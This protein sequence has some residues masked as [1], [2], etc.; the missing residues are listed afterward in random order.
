MKN[1]AWSIAVKPWRLLAALLPVLGLRP[2]AALAQTVPATP[3]YVD[4]IT[5]MDWLWMALGFIAIWFILY[6]MVYPFLLR[7]YRDDDCKTFFWSLFLLYSLTWLHLIFYV[8]FDYGFYNLWLR[9]VALFLGVLFLIWFL[10]SFLRRNP[11]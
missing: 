2:R 9:W 6:K 10:V 7:Y 4:Q 1:R 8:F 5:L 11:V 3:G